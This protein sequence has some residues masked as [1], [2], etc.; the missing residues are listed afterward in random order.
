MSAERN[1]PDHSLPNVLG[2]ASRKNGN[3]GARVAKLGFYLEPAQMSLFFNQTRALR[4][5]RLAMTLGENSQSKRLPESGP[6][7]AIKSL[8]SNQTQTIGP[9]GSF[10]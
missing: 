7:L 2:N 5:G 1:R 8:R 6:K 10:K 9:V 4:D 3:C